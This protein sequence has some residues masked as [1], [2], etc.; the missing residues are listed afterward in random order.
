MVIQDECSLRFSTCYSD[1][2]PIV[3]EAS[4]DVLDAIIA[5]EACVKVDCA[6]IAFLSSRTKSYKLRQQD[7]SNTQMVVCPQSGTSEIWCGATGVAHTEE[8]YTDMIPDSELTLIFE[9]HEGDPDMVSHLVYSTIWSED[10]IVS[11]LKSNDIYYFESN[12]WR[13]FSD[14]Q[15]YYL[16]DLVLN[17]CALLSNFNSEEVWISLNEEESSSTVSLCQVQYLMSR[18][19]VCPE[20]FANKG[21]AEWPLHIPMDAH[22]VAVHRGRQIISNANCPTI[23]TEE[24]IH[25]W[26]DL[27][28]ISVCIDETVLDNIHNLIDTTLTGIGIRRGNSIIIFDSRTLPIEVNARVNKLFQLRSQ[29]PK[30]QLEDFVRPVLAPGTKPD[31]LLLK[32]CRLDEDELGQLSYASRF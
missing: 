29:W 27:L 19:S 1:T 32:L 25:M 2:V 28:S 10:R 21:E 22:K 30:D 3:L 13:R 7:N 15:Y 31:A 5:G 9:K 17:A 12:V 20:S 23:D 18:L 26:R 4:S 14:S 24:F 8:V 6:G 11:H 16:M